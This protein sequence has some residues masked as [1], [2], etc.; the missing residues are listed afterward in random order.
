MTRL[1]PITLLV[2]G[3]TLVGYPAFR[4]AV[5]Y[6]DLFP[7]EGAAAQW[8]TLWLVIFAGHWLCVALVLGAIAAEGRTLTSIGLD[9][10]LF[11]R[12]APFF[13]LALVAFAAAAYAAPAFHYGSDPPDQMLSHPLGPVTVEQRLFWIAM[14]LTAGFTEEI[15]YRGFAIVRLR[16]LAGLPVALLASIAS[17]ALMHGPSAFAPQLLALY[18]VSGVAFSAAFLMFKSRRLE[19]LI[20]VHALLDLLLVTAP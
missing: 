19:I 9:L 4:M 12:R 13:I 1:P 6:L 20:I 3:L 16:A 7:A 10:G 8:W 18:L 5:S 14:A 11:R 2:L 17:F 15:I